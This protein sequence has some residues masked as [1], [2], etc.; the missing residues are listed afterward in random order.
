MGKKKATKK[1]NLSF[2]HSDLKNS[3]NT[4]LAN[5]KFAS[6]DKPIKS[7]V[8]TSVGMDEGKSTVSSN[9]ALAIANSGSSVVL[10]DSDLRK[11]SL[12]H[13][14]NCHPDHG[15]Y[16]LLSGSCSIEKA[17]TKTDYKNLYF[18]DCEPS[19]PNPADVLAS[20]R[21]EKLVGY[22]YKNYDYIVFD[23]PPLVSFVDGAVVGSI[24][25]ATVL[26]VREGKAKKA[27]VKD[28]VEQLQQ[29]KATIL[30]TVLS[31]ST[32]KSEG[33][34]YYAYYNK[35][36]KRIRKHGHDTMK[37]ENVSNSEADE[38][39]RSWLGEDAEDESSS[40]NMFDKPLFDIPVAQEPKHEPEP[41][42]DPEPE[43][44]PEPQTTQEIPEIEEPVEEEEEKVT[45]GHVAGTHVK[46]G[47]VFDDDD[48]DEEDDDDDEG[49]TYG[50]SSS[51]DI[52]RDYFTRA[53]EKLMG[54]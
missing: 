1:N 44:E 13:M 24:A 46:P 27:A 35:E 43:P 53:R 12:N 8:V 15:L 38:N 23:T 11:R 26:V 33:Y 14:V 29:A 32:D 42:P 48:D 19:I 25:D 2:N 5:I 18:L 37:I 49:I 47:Y 51:Q 28:A 21:F 7:I 10:V 36:G 20:E 17:I 6:I 31:F 39:L 54:N 50:S 45:G 41:E 40:S 30:G 3:F 9:L 16:A 4:L 52:A 34:Y 22:L